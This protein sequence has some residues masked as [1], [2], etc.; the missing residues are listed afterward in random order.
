MKSPV[1]LLVIL[2]LSI[3]VAYL[4]RS[5]S[6]G[7][8]GSGPACAP[9]RLIVIYETKALQQFLIDA[10]ITEVYVPEYNKV[11]ILTVDGKRGPITKAAYN[12]WNCN[13]IWPKGG[14]YEN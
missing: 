4:V 10:G 3:G 9:R 2:I 14:D 1:T 6:Q 11:C 5:C 8:I 7:D 13:N 12:Q